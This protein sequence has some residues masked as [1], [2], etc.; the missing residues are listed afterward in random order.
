MIEVTQQQRDNALD[1]LHIMWPSVPP[2]NVYPRLTRW[3]KDTNGAPSCGAVACFGG[4]CAWWPAFQAQGVRA[5]PF[6][7]RM[8]AG[9]EWGDAVAHF[10]FGDRRLF[11]PRGAAGDIKFEGTDHELV[12]HRL[13]ELIKNSEVAA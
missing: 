1:A 2:R 12:T 7:P 3:A 6:G 8:D 5:T 9:E 4:W 11:W 13:Q 10:L